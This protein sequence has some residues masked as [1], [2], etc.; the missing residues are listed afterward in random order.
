M[1]GESI[2]ASNLSVA[3]A[4]T[5]DQTTHTTDGTGM[6][7]SYSFD[8]EF[9]FEVAVVLIGV[10]G[11]VGNGL[12]L[13]ALFASKQHKKHALIVNQ[14]VLDLFASFFL[15]VVFILRLCNIRLTGVLGYWICIIIIGEYLVWVGNNGSTFNLAIITVDRYLKV[16]HP[17]WSRKY[18]RPRV[19]YCAMLSAWLASILYNTAMIF[20]T[21]AV[22][23]GHC[24]SYLFYDAEWKA[25][26]STIFY[27]MAYYVIILA[28]LIFCYGR[29]LVALRR[30]AR[31]MAAHSGPSSST[32]QTQSRQ[33]QTNIIKTMILVSALYAVCWMPTIAYLMS[34]HITRLN[35]LDPR[36][37]VCMFV[38][39]LYGA[40]NPFIYATKFDA[41]RKVLIDMIPCKKNRIQPAEGGGT[42]SAELAQTRMTKVNA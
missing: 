41:V 21:S 35:W 32:A 31:V 16:V 42:G 8:V 11:T 13:Y 30:Q 3:M 36:Y 9:Y 19:I 34:M 12:V 17:V 18:L 37:Y 26:I 24:Y 33:I 38:A 20:K 10:V 6:T 2:T 23:N 1:S 40:A 39:F 22:K 29:I 28:I 4:T 15:T 25:I 5:E 7:S 27:I 14:N